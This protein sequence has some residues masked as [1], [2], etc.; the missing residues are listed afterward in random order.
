[1][2]LKLQPLQPAA[3]KRVAAEVQLAHLLQTS[4]GPAPGVQLGRETFS[5]QRQDISHLKSFFSFIQSQEGDHHSL[6]GAALES[7]TAEASKAAGMQSALYSIYKDN[8]QMLC[9]LLIAYVQSCCEA[10]LSA[11]PR[12]SV[13]AQGTHTRQTTGP[14][15]SQSALLSTQPEATKRST[16][17]HKVRRLCNF[18]RL[19][20]AQSLASSGDG[21]ASAHKI[22][23]LCK[24][25]PIWSKLR[26]AIASMS[27]TKR[28]GNEELDVSSKRT[29]PEGSTVEQH[30]IAQPA[31]GLGTRGFITSRN[32]CMT[33]ATI[34]GG[35]LA[36][37]AAAPALPPLR[38]PA[39]LATPR[40]RYVHP[41]AHH[42]WPG[43]PQPA[44]AAVSTL[45]PLA[46]APNVGAS[47]TGSTSTL[48]SMVS[49][50]SSP[51]LLLPGPCPARGLLRSSASSSTSSMASLQSGQ[52]SCLS[53]H[54]SDAALHRLGTSSPAARI[55]VSPA[56]VTAL[57]LQQMSSASLSDEAGCSDQEDVE[58]A[59]EAGDQAAAA[60]PDLSNEQGGGSEGSEPDTT[61]TAPA[62]DAHVQLDSPCV[63]G[64]SCMAPAA[65]TATGAAALLAP[66]FLQPQ[67]LV[68]CDVPRQLVQQLTQQVQT[69]I[70]TATAL[71]GMREAGHKQGVQSGIPMV[72]LHTL[73]VCAQALEDGSTVLL[74]TCGAGAAAPH[75]SGAQDVLVLHQKAVLLK[76][77]V[78][79]LLGALGQLGS[80][81]PTARN[82]TGGQFHAD[83][84]QGAQPTACKDNVDSAEHTAGSVRALSSGPGAEGREVQVPAAA[85]VEAALSSVL[86]ELQEL[87]SL[88]Q[89]LSRRLNCTSAAE[90]ACTAA[91][92]VQLAPAAPGVAP[93]GTSA[94]RPGPMV[95]KPEAKHAVQVAKPQVGGSPVLLASNS[96]EAA[97]AACG[98]A[99]RL[100]AQMTPS[101]TAAACAP[102]GAVA[103][104]AAPWP[105][106]QQAGGLEAGGGETLTRAMRVQRYLH[107]RRSSRFAPHVKYVKRSEL[108]EQRPRVKGRFVSGKDAC[109][110]ARQEMQEEP[111][112]GGV[113]KTQLGPK[114]DS[115]SSTA[116]D[117]RQRSG[118]QQISPKRS[119]KH[120]AGHVQQ[121][122]QPDKGTMSAEHVAERATEQQQQQAFE[123]VVREPG[124]MV[125]L[126]AQPMIATVPMLVQVPFLLTGTQVHP[127]DPALLPDP[128]SY[129]AGTQL[130]LSPLLLMPYSSAFSTV[131]SLQTWV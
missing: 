24:K 75:E 8:E 96:T 20:H 32:S 52:G 43:L 81:A 106:Q 90:Q 76:K 31:P 131:T 18:L 5:F 103:H 108:A 37:P 29:R 119:A 91:S 17:E 84:G 23:L 6:I 19:A 71:R 125:T 97:A 93:Q 74:N 70:C 85:V 86:L 107:K 122:T 69:A 77:G 95:W 48:A 68:P 4:A 102:A 127:L 42:S 61:C 116:A 21:T 53:K 105:T 129:G 83:E 49:P 46:P 72:R 78:R 15:A 30:S 50:S 79:A 98:P 51:A 87:Q 126:A 2:Q 115:T 109:D 36:H 39:T 114:C 59:T 99:T 65:A 60:R 94:V 35:S 41:V 62:A 64:A 104:S 58:N 55:T 113:D 121:S 38:P 3:T 112:V 34:S 88:V 67:C 40:A 101:P 73:A 10:Q 89:A 80:T 16:L 44:P 26:G 22:N 27:G 63:A 128:V 120:E 57:L 117:A 124:S 12:D 123:V 7:E 110:L 11:R 33:E 1:M 82:A 92:S 130:S 56:A 66:A 118:S 28:S 25:H 9:D 54:S 100:A 14:T 111:G 47:L 13:A 45:L